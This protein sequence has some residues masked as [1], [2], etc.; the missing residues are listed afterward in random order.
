MG[1]IPRTLSG[2]VFLLQSACGC[3]RMGCAARSRFRFK[4]LPAY[5]AQLPPNPAGTFQ[6]TK[7]LR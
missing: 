4:R 7:A 6:C 1:L 5:S 2:G 3:L